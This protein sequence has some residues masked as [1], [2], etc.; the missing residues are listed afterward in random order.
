MMRIIT[1]PLPRSSTS[2]FSPQQRG[3]VKVK[4]YTRIPPFIQSHQAIIITNPFPPYPCIHPQAV[5][6]VS[7]PPISWHH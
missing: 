7:P 4:V 1:H 5:I 6:T 3:Y 2:P